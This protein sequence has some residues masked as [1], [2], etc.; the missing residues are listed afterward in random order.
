LLDACSQLK[1]GHGLFLF[2]DADKLK[3][4][5]FSPVWL[6]GKDGEPTGLLNEKVQPHS[7]TALDIPK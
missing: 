7:G 1:R 4:D 5:L 3:G 6:C 2:T